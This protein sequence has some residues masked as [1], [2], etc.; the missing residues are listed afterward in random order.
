MNTHSGRRMKCG[1]C[2]SLHVDVNWMIKSL[3]LNECL[4]GWGSQAHCTGPRQENQGTRVT[5][6]SQSWGKPRAKSGAW[7]VPDLAMCPPRKV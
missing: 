1:V 4:N 3:D 7:H 5:V 6:V 2:L